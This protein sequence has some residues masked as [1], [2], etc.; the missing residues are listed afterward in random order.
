MHTE[1]FV[2][3]P[4]WNDLW[5]ALAQQG[6]CLFASVDGEV[7]AYRL[8][9]VSLSPEPESLVR[10]AELY[11]KIIIQTGHGPHSRENAIASIRKA[12]IDWPSPLKRDPSRDGID[13][14]WAEI[15]AREDGEHGRKYEPHIGAWQT[16]YAVPFRKPKAV[17]V[18]LDGRLDLAR[19]KSLRS[20][21]D[22][23]IQLIE[24]LSKIPT[25]SGGGP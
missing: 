21:L 11:E 8:H 9:P 23:K 24:A 22:I 4:P 14:H 15:G 2:E 13:E 5:D 16:F 20:Q 6:W 25:E 18:S 7:R 17:V 19:L 1:I 10:E 3:P 12:G